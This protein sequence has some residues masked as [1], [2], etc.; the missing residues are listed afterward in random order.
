MLENLKTNELVETRLKEFAELNKKGNDEW[1]SELCFCILTSNSKAQTAINIQNQIG[2]K[3]FKTLEHQELAHVIR[4]NKHRFHNTKAK[5]IIEA[6]KFCDIKDKLSL[7]KDSA[8][9]REF[10][11]KNIK[12]LGYKEASHFLRNVGYS[13]VAIIDRHI[14]KYMKQA[15][16]I[17]E[18]PKVINRKF[19]LECEN[20]LYKLSN[21]LDQLDLIIWQKV[22]GKVLK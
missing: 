17:S 21:R 6:R 19:Y 18:I 1:F 2:F 14:L 3:G 7:F 11:V 12:G 13:D 9:A 15:G 8:Q 16:M 22:T 4:G 20:K 10:I 5:Y